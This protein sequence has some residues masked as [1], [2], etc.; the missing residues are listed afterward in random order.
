M[1]AENNRGEMFFPSRERAAIGDI[2]F[3]SGNE[4]KKSTSFFTFKLDRGAIHNMSHGEYGYEASQPV[5]CDDYEEHATQVLAGKKKVAGK[6]PVKRV[7][8]DV[9]PDEDDL[10]A[11]SEPLS[12]GGS[13]LE[14]D[15]DLEVELDEVI[16]RRHVK[17]HWNTFFKVIT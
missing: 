4:E 8:P 7:R 16:M 12:I 10:D 15:G 14:Q 9:L 1:L 13:D 6:E 3:F 11:G 5:D 2:I 17:T